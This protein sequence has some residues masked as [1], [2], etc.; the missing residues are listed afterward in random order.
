MSKKLY[1]VWRDGNETSLDGY[2][3]IFAKS[4]E[5]AEEI[6]LKMHIEPG[7]PPE[8]VEDYTAILILETVPV[9]EDVEF[10]PIL[11]GERYE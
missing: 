10:K 8:D 5:E 2:Y 6:C 7:E 9:G 3:F 11:K 1:A 4:K